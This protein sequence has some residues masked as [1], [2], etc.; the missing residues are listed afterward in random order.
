MNHG[1][2]AG[3]YLGATQAGVNPIA[4]QILIGAAAADTLD[5]IKLAI[6]GSA[7][8]WATPEYSYNTVA[9]PFVNATTNTDTVQTIVSDTEAYGNDIGTTN[10]ATHLSFTSTVMGSGLPKVV[11]DAAAGTK[12]TS[13]GISG[14]QNV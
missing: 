9:H 5:N 7:V 2:L 1:T 4:N 11:A 3:A 10:T 12:N 6:N 13:A 8:T 14:D